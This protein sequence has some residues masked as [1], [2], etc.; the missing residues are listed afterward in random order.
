[1]VPAACTTFMSLQHIA[2]AIYA[3]ASL[4]YHAWPAG[5]ASSHDQCLFCLENQNMGCTDPLTRTQVAHQV[6]TAITDSLH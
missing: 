5:I 4:H 6:K 2:A 1:M 3:C